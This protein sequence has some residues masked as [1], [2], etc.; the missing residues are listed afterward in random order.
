MVSITS[1]GKYGLIS[2]NP[3]YEGASKK[4][5]GLR[6][7]SALNFCQIAQRLY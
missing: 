5:L 4:A 7:A 2:D 1:I 3:I 6:L